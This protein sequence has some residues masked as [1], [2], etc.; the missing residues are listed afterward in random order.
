MIDGDTF[1][2]KIGRA[3]ESVRLIGVNTP[4][5]GERGYAEAKA[6][7]KG[8]LDGRIVKMEP[9]KANRDRYGRLLRYVW[10]NG[11]FVNRELVRLG[12]AQVEQVEPNIKRIKEIEK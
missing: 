5:V 12:V 9:D 3:I 10:V 8:L 11:K 4:E 2:V 6:I 7:A 1:T